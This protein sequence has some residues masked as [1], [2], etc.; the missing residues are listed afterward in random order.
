MTKR[1]LIQRG[2]PSLTGKQEA[3]PA[4]MLRLTPELKKE[5]GKRAG[6]RKLSIAAFVR[7]VLAERLQTEEIAS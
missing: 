6:K 2:R 3:T 1:K 7:L 4:F 5:I